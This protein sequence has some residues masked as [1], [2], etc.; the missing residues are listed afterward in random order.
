MDIHEEHDI[1]DSID[2]VKYH[3]F[4]LTDNTAMYKIELVFTRNSSDSEK[5]LIFS[6]TRTKITEIFNNY[7]I[8]VAYP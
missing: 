6:P 1:V 7:G 2:I 5:P 8:N 3:G 4:L